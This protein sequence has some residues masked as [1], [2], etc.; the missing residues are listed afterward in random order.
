MGRNKAS[1]AGGVRT[2]RIWFCAKTC[3]A[4]ASAALGPRAATFNEDADLYRALAALI[5]LR[6]KLLPL[7]RGRQVLHQ[8][9]DDDAWFA[10]DDGRRDRGNTLISWSRLFMDEEVL[11]ALNTDLARPTTRYSTVA[12][13]FRVEGDE[14]RRIYWYAPQP[15]SPPPSSLTVERKNGMLAV[16]L[17]VPPAGFLMYQSAP[18]LHRFGPFPASGL[19]PWEPRAF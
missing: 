10:A 4:A 8:V 3:L 18:S 6:K 1:T 15:V 19:K 16:R 12:P 13:T 5:D 7:R 2:A 14:F 11:V 9:T 17:T